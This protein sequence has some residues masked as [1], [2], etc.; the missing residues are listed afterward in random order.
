MLFWRHAVG[1]LLAGSLLGLEVSRWLTIWVFLDL[2]WTYS[3]SG[4]CTLTSPLFLR[5]R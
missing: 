1:K 5:L 2:L 4:Y 3:N